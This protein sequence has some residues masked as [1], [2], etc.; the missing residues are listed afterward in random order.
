MRA[1]RDILCIR[2]TVGQPKYFVSNL[3]APFR[4]ISH[5]VDYSRELDAERLG[6][7]RGNGVLANALE[8]IHAVEAKGIDFYDGLRAGGG[9]F[10][11]G[12]DVEVFDRAFA[13][14]DIYGLSKKS[15]SMMHGFNDRLLALFA[16]CL[17]DAVGYWRLGG[18]T[19]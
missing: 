13:I 12:G 4:F 15:I 5:A 14:F 1:H 7:M 9:R 19:C 3:E 11:D 6:G 2:T 18:L 8:E 17:M 16:T 10:G